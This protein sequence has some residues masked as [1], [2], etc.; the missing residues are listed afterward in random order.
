MHI[1]MPCHIM[2]T[3]QARRLVQILESD[4]RTKPQAES[5]AKSLVFDLWLQLAMELE[6]HGGA[7]FIE[8]ASEHLMN[9]EMAKL[10]PPLLDPLPKLTACGFLE[11][12][13]SGG[14][15][16]C[17]IF[18]FYNR[19][20]DKN[21]IP[22]DETND[23]DGFKKRMEKLGLECLGQLQDID[24]G[25]WLKENGERMTPGEMRSCLLLIKAID[26]T[27]ALGPR[28]SNEY[29]RGLVDAAA[30]IVLKHDWKKV[31]MVL[32]RL[33][34]KK[35]STAIQRRTSWCL[36][37]FEQLICAIAHPGGWDDWF[38][39]LA[40]HVRGGR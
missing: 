35:H 10:S 4:E 34:Q 25:C 40:G 14:G 16:L 18:Q 13:E 32:L 2:M 12:H 17:P 36:S 1:G 30:R 31:E 26:S 5:R 24:P 11:K 3:N 37:N 28:K 15:W 8:A 27:L 6:S 33:E 22:E 19:S 21:Y 20:L 29:D 7:G 38:R 9:S 39:N 23:Y